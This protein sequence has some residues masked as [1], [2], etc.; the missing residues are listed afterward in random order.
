[1]VRYG[2]QLSLDPCWGK[3]HKAGG[4]AAA[5]ESLGYSCIWC[6]ETQRAFAKAAGLGFSKAI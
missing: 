6:L 4:Y 5:L 2:T 3:I 1:M